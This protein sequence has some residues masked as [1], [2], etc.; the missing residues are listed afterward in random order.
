MSKVE[1]LMWVIKHGNPKT[2]AKQLRLFV[3]FELY[4]L[5]CRLSGYTAFDYMNHKS[6]SAGRY[7]IVKPPLPLGVRLLNKVFPFG[8]EA[9]TEYLPFT[10]EAAEEMRR[11]GKVVEGVDISYE[12]RSA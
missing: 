5:G 2:H 1:W 9:H 12:L 3:A 8:A 11:A 10:P 4:N 6:L 7:I